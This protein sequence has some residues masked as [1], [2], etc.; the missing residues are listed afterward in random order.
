MV[1]LFDPWLAGQDRPPVPQP[2]RPPCGYTEGERDQLECRLLAAP[3]GLRPDQLAAR[4]HF[5][6]PTVALIL[7]DMLC[8]G[9]VRAAETS[10][11]D[12]YTYIPAEPWNEEIG[13]QEAE[14][15]RAMRERRQLKTIRVKARRRGFSSAVNR[16]DRDEPLI[17]A[18]EL[19][20]LRRHEARAAGRPPVP[21]A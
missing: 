5:A 7:R 16:P 2:V 10:E 8:E 20:I 11:G 12:V 1:T 3:T 15:Y 6:P 17:G 18:R 19:A 9:R 21:A 4:L 13:W 14:A